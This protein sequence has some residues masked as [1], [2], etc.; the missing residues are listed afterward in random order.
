MLSHESFSCWNP[1]HR[2]A[3]ER[4]EALGSVVF[5]TAL[6]GRLYARHGTSVETRVTVIDK[7]GETRAPTIEQ[8]AIPLCDD[9]E[10]LCRIIA[11]HV[12]PRLPVVREALPRMLAKPVNTAEWP[13]SSPS[14]PRPP[15]VP[16]PIAPRPV[17]PQPGPIALARPGASS[18]SDLSLSP[19][20]YAARISRQRGTGDSR[21]VDQAKRG[22]TDSVY[23]PYEVQSIAFKQSV[24]HPTA[25][26]ESI[27]M[28]AVTPPV[29][30]YQPVLPKRLLDA[31]A[32]SDPQ[33][34]TVVMAGEAHS[35]MLPGWFTVSDTLDVVTAATPV[36]DSAIQFRRGYFV[37]DGTGAG[38]GGRSPAS[39]RIIGIKAADARCGSPNP[40]S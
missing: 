37:G 23:V 40:T 32:L 14:R 3:F 17:I 38:K 6:A 24:P 27:A 30:T 12:P 28:A 26:V 19:V 7:H 8:P 25:L 13:C 16:R 36:T 5:S 9:I 39:S 11:D 4:L 31:R 21:T 1:I 20:A 33:M 29:P 35:A 34:E 10:T 2:A 15:F 22:D 18:G